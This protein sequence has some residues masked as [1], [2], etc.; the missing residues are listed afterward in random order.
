MPRNL[1][2][3]AKLQ[4]ELARAVPQ[5]AETKKAIRIGDGE[6][7]M[8]VVR[9]SGEASWVLRYSLAGERRDFTVGRWPATTLKLARELAD[10]A[11]QKIAAGLDP[12][13][14]KRTERVERQAS[15][16]TVRRL[17]E[18]WTATRAPKTS[19]RYQ[20]NIR[21]AF[22]K[23]VLPAIGSKPPERVERAE[24]LAI[25]RKIEAR[26]AEVMVGRVRMW[27]RQMFDFGVDDE[28]RERLTV[29]PVPTGHMS[30][31]K[32]YRRRKGHYPAITDPEEVPGLMR[33]CRR[34]PN[35]II[36]AAL[37]FSAYVWQR[38]TEIREATWREFDLDAAKWVIPAARMKGEREH[39]V[40]LA[41]QVVALLRHHQGVVGDDPNAWLFPGR[42]YGKPISAGTLQSYLSS[43][44]FEGRHCPHGFRATA[45]TILVERLRVPKDHAEKQLSHETDE[46]GLDGAYDR[47]QYWDE[48]VTMMKAWAD[49]LDEQK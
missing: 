2:S 33:L 11:R 6:G 19:T 28:R 45:R 10:A 42:K 21:A 43:H 24:I 25:L 37:L 23:D 12:V 48:R 5:A 46:S 41:P 47:A 36:R 39:W 8:L 14:A 26:D 27:L 20:D 7:L 1:L 38:P 15:D 9:P 16:D 44:G 3:A 18:D 49:W 22:T 35:A 34:T 13:Q 31:F 32:G 40:P 29:S 30:S 17:F 4:A